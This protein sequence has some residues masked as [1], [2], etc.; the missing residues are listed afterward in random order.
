MANARQWQ[1]TETDW[2][3][4]TTLNPGILDWL[5]IK[6]KQWSEEGYEYEVIYMNDKA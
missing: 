2:I 4:L 3:E 6:N 5:E 1:D